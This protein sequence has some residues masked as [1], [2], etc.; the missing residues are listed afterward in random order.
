MLTVVTRIVPLHKW[1]CKSQARRSALGAIF[2]LPAT[3]GLTML[4]VC[5]GIVFGIQWL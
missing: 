3:L 4:V 5:K 2:I 1:S